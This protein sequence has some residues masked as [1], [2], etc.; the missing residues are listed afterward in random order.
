MR[1]WKE[2][3]EQALAVQDACN[4][5]GVVISF[6]T[7]IK[8]VRARLEEEK[9]GGTD[10]VNTHPVCVL[11]ADK[12]AHLTGTQSLGNDV[13]SAAYTWAYKQ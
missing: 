4:L 6:A 2:L 1:T 9:Q 5:S 3:A 10:N 8:E 11:F 13:V 7:I 12:I